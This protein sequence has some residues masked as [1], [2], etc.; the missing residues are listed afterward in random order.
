[1]KVLLS[2][3]KSLDFETLVPTSKQSESH[4]LDEAQKVHKVLVRKK[5]KQLSE[6]MKISDKLA[7]LNWQRNQDWQVPFPEGEARQAV[8]AFNGDVY[9]GLDVYNLPEDKI[10]SLQDTV[11]ILSGLYGV[12][13]PLDMIL[14]YRLEMGTKLPVSRKKNLYEFW[15]VKLTKYLNEEL[16]EGELLVNL[17]SKEYATAVDLKKIK[18]TVIA[19]EFKDYKNGKL[20]IISFF[21]KKA[22][23]VMARYI[24]DNNIQTIAELKEFDIDGYG[25]D[26]GLSTDV[27]LVFTR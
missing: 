15:K 27:Q 19:I 10:D 9:T 18:S 3:A 17:A 25:F 16:Q 2:P 24:V 14:P 1:M 8:Y 22:R 6:L 5:P 23:G 20:K 11:R 12:L 4:F 21:A 13:Q 7:E 26:A